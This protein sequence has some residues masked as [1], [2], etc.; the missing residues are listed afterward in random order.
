M[1][2]KMPLKEK[3]YRYLNH[4]TN[5]VTFKYMKNNSINKGVK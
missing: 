2:I 4:V 3:I 1:N 5:H